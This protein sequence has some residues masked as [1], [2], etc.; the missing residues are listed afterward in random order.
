[1]RG[2]MSTL[3]APVL[4]VKIFVNRIDLKNPTTRNLVFLVGF[5]QKVHKGNNFTEL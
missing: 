2:V 4:Y 5:G 1:M 3:I